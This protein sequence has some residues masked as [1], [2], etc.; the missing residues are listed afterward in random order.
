MID[1]PRLYDDYDRPVN[2]AALRRE[3]A[4]PQVA[5]LRTGRAGFGLGTGVW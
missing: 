2:L 4:A 3:H 5:R 1:S